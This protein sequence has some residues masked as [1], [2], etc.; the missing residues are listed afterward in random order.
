MSEQ[1]QKVRFV[2][3]D[4]ECAAWHYP[5]NNGACIVMAGGFAVTKEPA[6]DKFARRFSESGFTVLA[7]DYRRLGESGGQP[8]LVQPV[9]DMLADWQAAI[10]CARTLPGVDP[11]RVAVWGF[12][13]SGGHVFRLAARDRELAAAI[14]QTPN[15]DGLAASRN[16]ARYQKT[17][18]LLRFTSIGIAD[19]VGSLAGRPPRLVPLAGTPGT[20]AVLTTPDALDADSAFGGPESYPDWQRAVAARSALRLG[21]YQPGRDASRVRCPLQ[22]VVCD[23]DQSSLAGPAI[24]AARR[25]PQ[26]E[27]VRLR[28][29]H[30]APF[31][32]QHEHAVEAQ[33]SF[34][35]RHLLEGAAAD[36]TARSG[37]RP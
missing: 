14:A 37:A 35:R 34:L 4:N 22:V 8:R 32:D 23:Q 17:L 30:Y 33:L 31:L 6:T 15:A 21:F 11:A 18:A 7:F 26:A 12:S 36:A 9:R 25:A 28:G 24:R 13:A 1:R 2:S 27:V 19:A 16:A 5:G 3:G 20:V 29:G 10:G